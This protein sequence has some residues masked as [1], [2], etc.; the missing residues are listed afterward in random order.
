MRRLWLGAG[1]GLW[2]LGLTAAAA[3]VPAMVQEARLD[4]DDVGAPYFADRFGFSVAA[5]GAT[6][7]VGAIFA[8]GADIESG[9]VRVFV[10][11]A[12][13]WQE[14]QRLAGPD[15][16]G[17]F[18][19][20][21]AL[22][23]D[24]LVVGRPGQGAGFPG[25]GT[26]YVF[27]RSG[28]R[29]GLE[30]ELV[31]SGNTVFARFGAA[32]A[33][34]G[35]TILVGAPDMYSGS[36]VVYAFQ[37][38]PS[39]WVQT[40]ILTPSIV[41]SSFGSAVA[42]RDGQALVG[43]SGGGAY[44]FARAGGT[45]LET[46]RFEAPDGA[47]GD[48]FGASVAFGEGCLAIGAPGD[49]TAAV[50]AGSV[51]VYSATPDWTGPQKLTLLSPGAGDRLGS[52]LAL[53]PGGE[54]LVAGAPGRAQNAGRAYVFERDGGPWRLAAELQAADLM[55]GDGFGRAV[56][57][58]TGELWIGADHDDSVP[59][60]SGV[61]YVFSP[62]GGNWQQSQRVPSEGF[63]GGNY[64]GRAVALAGDQA[65]VA[66]PGDDLGFQRA[67]GSVHVHD[68]DLA[69]VWSRPQPKLRAP[70]G[71]EGDAFGQAVALSPDRLLIGAPGAD[72]PPLFG[73]GALYAFAR[74]GPWA[75]SQKLTA[76]TPSAN[77]GFGASAAACAST[78]VVGEPGAAGTGQVHVFV[79]SAGTWTHQAVLAPA[80]GSA[81]DGF[82]ARVAC[83][84]DTAVVAADPAEKVYVFVRSGA[85]WAQQQV[86]GAPVAGSR[87][88][89][90]V[91]VSGDSLAI[92]S[93]YENDVE[94]RQGAVR[95]YVRSGSNWSLE[96][97]LV[98]SDPQEYGRM[99]TSV[100]LSGDT[101]AA[102]ATGVPGAAGDHLGALYRFTR[103]LGVWTQQER[104]QAS[105]AGSG[106][107][108]GTSLALSG[109]RLLAA[110]EYRLEPLS[111]VRT[112]AAYVFSTLSPGASADLALGKSDYRD[113]VARG[114]VLTYDVTL[115][116]GG[117]VPVNGARVQDAPP[118]GLD[119][120]WLCRPSAGAA[121]ATGLLVGVLDDASASL[122][123][124]GSVTWS[125]S[126]SV[127]ASTPGV[128]VNTA[129]VTP[130]SVPADPNPANDS[131]ADSTTVSDEADLAVRQFHAPEPAGPGQPVTFGFVASNRGG[132]VA[133]GASLQWDVPAGF[134]VLSAP[135]GCVA[136]PPLLT[137][138]LGDLAA[139]SQV[140]IEATVLAPQ[141]RESAQ[142]VV[143]VQ[144]ATPDPEPANDESVQHVRVELRKGD[145]DNDL[146]TDLVLTRVGAPDAVAWL[147]NG[148][149]RVLEAPFPPLPSADWQVVGVDDFTGDARSDLV[150]QRADTGAVIFLPMGGPLGTTPQGDPVALS[151]GAVL[152][153]NWRVAATADFDRDDQP[154]LLWRN[155]DSGKLVIWTMNGTVRV[156]TRL[157][158]PGQAVDGNWQVVAAVD[159]N[160][161]AHVDLV[162]YNVS[163]GKAVI[164]FLDDALS[165]LEGR[166]TAPASA[167]DAN[168]RIVAASD[169]GVGAGG[170]ALPPTADLL[171]RN[172][173]SGKLVVWHMDT[174]GRRTAGT[175]TSP[176]A[177][178]EP[179]AWRVAA[180]R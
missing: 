38:G 128:L 56:G 44:L 137:C 152:P 145:F 84:G 122:P 148:T 115:T 26:V 144:S 51:Y 66:E 36:G 34:R 19:Y 88:G 101:L 121:C 149:A 106:D 113:S 118:A 161:D 96:Q 85:A 130:P 59:I 76:P 67:V 29:W 132:S 90:A 178:D 69:G 7:A 12:G 104:L 81:G 20:S 39:G 79:L 74:N 110:A 62:S 114:Q 150:V 8:N 116:N 157:P 35:D 1:L 60:S 156:G 153:L 89:G 17:T 83:D 70:D 24:R 21:L 99:G 15:E 159:V 138:E 102:G 168:W 94:A 134:S 86:I 151:G 68:R 53:A 140:A 3:P 33:V 65:A 57:L 173:T 107:R 169:F 40:Q 72:Q 123:P 119:C 16:W 139:G 5:D 11:E 50:D 95:V 129:G 98:P 158:T 103:D 125:G 14:Q 41:H 63:P 133:T 162:W 25:N 166:F 58:A 108:L 13:T 52:S 46:R 146:R 180:P 23:G 61:A 127:G 31:G 49:D 42:L 100:G 37:L 176:P 111:G 27:R 143:A 91:A 141:A 171:W 136:L 105:D 135:A 160:G 10:R 177:P 32:V 82:G 6:A 142:S 155:A 30:A 172:E 75:F 131:A 167:G 174:D 22:D 87:F 179:L 165:R 71:A 2:G 92:G 170:L 80:D 18:G 73:T 4:P 126:C 124:G 93:D 54:R 147:M 78:A 28:R 163:S 164:W 154:D 48:G 97:R 77:G 64:A 43:A 55:N 45:W 117:A 9:G 175:F 120:H 109:G 47:L 112:G